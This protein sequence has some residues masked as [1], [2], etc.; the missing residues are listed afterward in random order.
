M[1]DIVGLKLRMFFVKYHNISSGQRSDYQVPL[2]IN[3]D[4]R[5]ARTDLLPQIPIVSIV[6]MVAVLSIPKSGYDRATMRLTKEDKCR[7]MDHQFYQLFHENSY[8]EKRQGFTSYQQS[9][10]QS[11]TQ[12][13]PKCPPGF[14]NKRPPL[15]IISFDGFRPDY[16]KTRK[17]VLRNFNAVADCGVRAEF[18]R[19]V[20]P[21][22]TFPNHYSIVTVSC[23]ALRMPPI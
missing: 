22:K 12:H 11:A 4:Y 16:L 2:M 5:L 18:M 6:I 8:T 14:R 19:P 3:V 7:L 9:N 23:M 13:W 15:V 20:F 10:Q 1:F 17:D 21:T